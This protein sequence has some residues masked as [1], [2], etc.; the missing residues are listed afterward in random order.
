MTGT[1]PAHHPVVDRPVLAEAGDEGGPE[2]EPPGPPITPQSADDVVEAVRRSLAVEGG[3][4]RSWAHWELSAP[5]QDFVRAAGRHR[6]IG[7]IASHGA[8][9]GLDPAACALLRPAVRAWAMQ[10]MALSAGTLRVHR[11]LEQA[12]LPHLFHKG[13]A[14]A[15]QTTGRAEARGGGDIDVL[16][17]VADA[18][19]AHQALL[20]AG[21]R[22][23]DDGTPVPGDGAAWRWSSYVYRERTYDGPGH[24]VDL[25][26]RIGRGTAVFPPTR[27][28]LDRAVPVG[29]GGAPVP[30]LSPPDA[31]V[32]ACY[33]AVIDD[34]CSARHLLD[35][36]RLLRLAGPDDLAGT[37]AA[38]RRLV[39]EVTGLVTDLLGPVGA[40]HAPAAAGVLRT[41]WEAGCVWGADARRRVPAERREMVRLGPRL[42]EVG[43]S[44]VRE[45]GPSSWARLLAVA[46]LPPDLLAEDSVASPLRTVLRRGGE[47]IAKGCR[48]RR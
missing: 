23:R 15:A 5:V 6:V 9:T 16:L 17:D 26:W 29:V 43:R 1:P 13:A 31:L 3:A 32:A 20:A 38:G 21:W 10:G 11:L 22:P 40:R 4:V 14:L 12:R 28:L 39:R 7:I 34:L 33:T 8:A 36:A 19:A 42:A 46:A 48:P 30:T 47:R 2:H 41:R 27:T 24:Q 45:P 44:L 35:V 25:H 18:P 37:P